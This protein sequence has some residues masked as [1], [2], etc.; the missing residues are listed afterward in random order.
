MLDM[1][2]RRRLVTKIE[3]FNDK[4]LS[5]DISLPVKEKIKIRH[6]EAND[7]YNKLL[8]RPV[9]EIYT[10]YFNT[11]GRGQPHE[12]YGVEYEEYVPVGE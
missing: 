3:Y 7:F 8:T 1:K 9:D 6:R 5:I 11:Y 4:T 12:S 2:T 10:V